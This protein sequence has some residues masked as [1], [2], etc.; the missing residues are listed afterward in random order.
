MLP[1]KIR[2]LE[3]RN[4]IL[5]PA[6]AELR[7]TVT[8]TDLLSEAEVRGRLVGPRCHYATT[9]EV[10]YPLRPLSDDGLER[11]ELGA[12]VIIPEPSLW[13]PESPS[14]YQGSA[15]VWSGGER[16]CEVEL[17]HGLR[18]L[19]LGKGGLRCN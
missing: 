14:L 5:N 2:R 18:V 9:V 6:E 12:R 11:G 8:P 1:A 15:E 3:V 13:D 7:I 19:Q 10:A 16:W 4:H 17:I